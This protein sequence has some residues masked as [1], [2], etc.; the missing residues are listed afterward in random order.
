MII[1]D[2]IEDKTTPL[3]VDTG[4]G[5]FQTTKTTTETTTTGFDLNQLGQ[6]GQED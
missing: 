2:T 3:T 5:G 1:V 4:L 6:L